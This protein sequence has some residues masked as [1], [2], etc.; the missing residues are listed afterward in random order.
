MNIVVCIKQVPA[1]TQVKLNPITNT[2]IRDGISST[3]NIYDMHAIEAALELRETHGGKVTVITMGPAQAKDVLKTAVGMTVDETVLI[4]DR[5]FAGADTLATSY[6]LAQ[7]I[8]KLGDA[9]LI[10]CGKQAVDGDTAQVGPGIAQWLNIPLVSCVTAIEKAGENSI[11]VRRHMD[12]GEDVVESSL[13]AL[14]TVVKELNQ[15]RIE[16]VRGRIRAKDCEIPVMTAQ[17]LECDSDM[18]GL[19]GSPTF[20]SKVFVP[21]RSGSRE[22][23]E[24]CAGEQ[25]CAIV[26]KLKQAQLI[27]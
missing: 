18:L 13:P 27:S 21:V 6:T 25:A 9:D 16:S 2:L 3:V 22:T 7:A 15:P 24:G 4:S 12:D 8:K 20:V 11:T 14:L 10:L 17:D 5:A 23:I 19:K 26:E 1:T